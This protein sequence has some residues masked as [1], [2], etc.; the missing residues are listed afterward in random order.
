MPMDFENPEISSI[1]NALNQTGEST[2]LT[3]EIRRIQTTMLPV[4]NLL[5]V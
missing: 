1:Y 2:G 4:I 5:N 3:G